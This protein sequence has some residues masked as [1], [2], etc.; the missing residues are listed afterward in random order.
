M[1]AINLT[2]SIGRETAITP[3]FIRPRIERARRLA[4]A[5]PNNASAEGFQHA[6]ISL[7]ERVEA[8]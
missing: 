6:S 5:L 2:L 4:D 8:T 1:L 7:P 3:P